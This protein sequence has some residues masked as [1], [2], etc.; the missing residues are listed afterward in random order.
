MAN[1]LLDN[2]GANK[3]AICGAILLFGDHCQ[4]GGFGKA[5]AKSQLFMT[6]PLLMYTYIHVR[7]YIYICYSKS[8]ELD[9]PRN[10]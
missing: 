1:M 6:S 7:M 4:Y 10:P 5:P 2:N 3:G 8:A 9:I